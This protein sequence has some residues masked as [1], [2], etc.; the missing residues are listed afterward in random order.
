MFFLS[1][2]VDSFIVGLCTCHN[3]NTTLTVPIGGLLL[4][5]SFIFFFC[6]SK[7]SS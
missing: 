3:P 6:F 1:E 2:V 7:L 5:K 4:E